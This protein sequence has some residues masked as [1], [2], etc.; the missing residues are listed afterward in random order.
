MDN[1]KASANS[2]SVG[3]ALAVLVPLE[4]RLEACRGYALV[5]RRGPEQRRE[6]G[7]LRAPE[8][9]LARGGGQ[10]EGAREAGHRAVQHYRQ[11]RDTSRLDPLNC[12]KKSDLESC[13]TSWLR[14]YRDGDT[15]YFIN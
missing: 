13:P 12:R 11:E 5:Q 15:R 3:V 9:A 10:L 2:F 7:Q 1:P 4:A 14:S 6:P 8:P